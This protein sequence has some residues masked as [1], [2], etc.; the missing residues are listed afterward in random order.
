MASLPDR[1]NGRGMNRH[2]F[3]S[4]TVVILPLVA[5]RE[6]TRSVPEALELA[7]RGLELRGCQVLMPQ[8]WLYDE[9]QVVEQFDALEC[10]AD[11]VVFFLA[12]WF[13]APAVVTPLRR[14][15][16]PC[17]LWSLTTIPGFA[18]GGAVVAKYTLQEMG[19]PFKF[20]AGL[21]EESEMLDAVASR[22]RAAMIANK[23]DGAKFGRIGGKSMGMYNATMDEFY[24]KK[25]AGFDIVHIDTY[26]IARYVER[27]SESAALRVLARVKD[28]VGSIVAL[29]EETG[30]T[31]CDDDLLAQCKIYLA[32][33]EIVQANDLVAISN[34][35]QPELSS[36]LVGMGYTGCVSHAL[37]NDDCVPCTCEA[38]MP[39]A[40]S[41]YILSQ[42]AQEPV[43]FGDLNS[44]AKEKNVARFIN[45]GSG[46]FSMA[47]S[48]DQ[49]T[50][51]PVSEGM[52]LPGKARGA[53]TGFPLRAGR[54]TLAKIG[55]GRGTARMHIAT[56]ECMDWPMEPAGEWPTHFPQAPVRL[57]GD[58]TEFVQK[59]IAQHYIMAYGDYS[60]EL[61]DL[62]EI[63]GIAADPQR[64]TGR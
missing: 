13:Y 64:N 20:L 40:V 59:A 26:Q 29:N 15:K 61:I 34:K 43:Y 58:V 16:K 52:G 7:R 10:E 5:P 63:L 45:C 41:M 49:V 53:C 35:C 18:L 9:A 39:S 56:G 27:V 12:T 23:L 55:G 38:D 47:A 6:D 51:W 2:E 28:S 19:L 24:W 48:K 3:S 11:L 22:A 50:L 17:V 44:L 30:E 14:A 21:P 42:L 57:D 60:R 4:P 36:D 25:A 31:L 8:E 62:C 32:L 46:P 54:V 1:E 33:R 37:L